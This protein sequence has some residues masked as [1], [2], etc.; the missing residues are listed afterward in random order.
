MVCPQWW[1]HKPDSIHSDLEKKITRLRSLVSEWMGCRG[2]DRKRDFL[3]PKKFLQNQASLADSVPAVRAT[4]FLQFRSTRACTQVLFGD[5]NR[6][7]FWAIKCCSNSI[8][9]HRWCHMVIILRQGVSLRNCP[10]LRVSFF[11]FYDICHL[12]WQQTCVFQQ[13]PNPICSFILGS[14][15]CLLAFNLSQRFKAALVP[16]NLQI[17]TWEE[18]VLL[19]SSKAEE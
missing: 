12:N 7:L 16:G 19:F 4:P 6:T 11:F 10:T 14:A 15:T 3:V 1:R 8:Q 18:L 17:K 2:G 5:K 13:T 9:V